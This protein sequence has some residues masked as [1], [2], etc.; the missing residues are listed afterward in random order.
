MIIYDI[1][2]FKENHYYKLTFINDIFYIKFKTYEYNFDYTEILIDFYWEVLLDYKPTFSYKSITYGW[3]VYDIEN[4][5]YEE[6][7]FSEVVNY[8]PDDDI[9]KKVY[10]R[11]QK[12]NN[13]LYGSR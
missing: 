13:L 4:T 9:D 1:D 2:D 5:I 8:L 7:Y 11:K 12:I 10:I 6:V 3:F